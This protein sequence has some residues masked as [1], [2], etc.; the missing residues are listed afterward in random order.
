M[1]SQYYPIPQPTIATNI[2][3]RRERRLPVPGEVLV[4]AGQRGVL[5][6]VTVGNDEPVTPDII[7]A[8]VTY[9]IVLGGAE[10][11]ADALRRMIELGARGVIVGSIRSSELA[12]FLGYQGLSVGD[13]VG[14]PNT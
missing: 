8:R 1:L 3:V 10:V 13:S 9:A 11:T 14:G 5:K 6:V 7:D 2:L 4:K 12:D